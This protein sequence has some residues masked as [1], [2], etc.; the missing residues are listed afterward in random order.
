M[1]Y[2]DDLGVA[3]DATLEQI[4]DAYR[5]LVRLLHPDRHADPVLKLTADAQLRRINR[6]AEI[7]LNPEQRR[8]Y[9]A[10]L[11][12][13]NERASPIIIRALPEPP[14]LQ[15]QWG[16]LAWGLAVVASVAMIFWLSSQGDTVTEPQKLT[17]AHDLP[18]ARKQT[19]PRV[20]A[21]QNESADEAKIQDLRR[22]LSVT[23]AQRDEA[24]SMLTGGIRT[25][26]R[27]KDLPER[28][29]PSSSRPSLREFSAPVLETETPSLP[30]L[31]TAPPTIA[32]NAFAG[33]WVY[34]RQ[35]DQ[36]KDKSLYLP[37]FI[38][39]SIVERNG[40]IHGKYRSRYRI[41]DR[42]IS[43]N[44]N[45]EFDG[46]PAGLFAKMPWKG[47]GGSRGEVQ[48]KLVSDNSIEIVWSATELGQ[49]LAL[50]SGT[51]VLMRR[52]E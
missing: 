31:S 27:S 17:P 22:E 14:R 43:P 28:D 49:S 2:Y 36:N 33:F 32:Q 40:T 46:Q 38:E 42:A 18:G 11:A 20:W 44:V 41:Y 26:P 9:D 16:T 29:A 30:A 6:S 13:A 45:F 24:L 25:P 47:E 48:I 21:V 12:S 19:V 10:E 5:T 51:A 50:G 34:P 7:L 8:L 4:R 23:R 39:T 35:K 1:S 52:P 3:Q 15:I 37:E